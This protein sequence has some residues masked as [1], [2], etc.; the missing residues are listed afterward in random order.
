MPGDRLPNNSD[1]MPVVQRPRYAN[2]SQKI[3]VFCGSNGNNLEDEGPDPKDQIPAW[4]NDITEVIQ[5][6]GGIGGKA[7]QANTANI[8]N[9]SSSS[10][11]IIGF[12]SGA[13][14]GLMFAEKF[15]REKNRN[16]TVKGIAL[17]AGT[18]TGKMSDGRDLSQEWRGILDNLL[19]NGVDVYIVDDKASFG[20]EASSYTPP[21]GATGSFFFDSRPSQEHWQ[22]GY[23]GTGTNNSP[24]FRD[25]VFNW[26]A[27]N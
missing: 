18:M 5:Y 24:S 1:F 15:I 2:T 23:P 16:V 6:K 17:L 4:I 8:N 14:A 9:Y 26:F 3:I 22:G 27:S 11:F 25:Y 13:D 12:S 21:D 19:I 20:D 7:G 10:V